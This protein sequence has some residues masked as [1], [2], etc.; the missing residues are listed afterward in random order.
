MESSAKRFP[1]YCMN[2]LVGLIA[3]GFLGHDVNLW[4]IAVMLITGMMLGGF[5]WRRWL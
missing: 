1:L 4:S 5:L 2:V 3:G